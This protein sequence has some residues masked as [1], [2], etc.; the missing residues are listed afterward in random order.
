MSAG[1]THARLRSTEAGSF[2]FEP[3]QLGLEPTDLFVE[4]SLQ[5]LVLDAGGLGAALEQLLGTVDELLLPG[6]DHRRMHA[7]QRGQLANRLVS[8][9]R[10]Q[11]HLGLEPG[12][13]GLPFPRH[14]YPFLG[15]P[16]V[17]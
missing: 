11:R 13:M 1:S 9:H 16:T 3:V 12:R 7:M 17:A 8:L 4:L 14:G 2:F 6:M 15:Q 5:R 10:R